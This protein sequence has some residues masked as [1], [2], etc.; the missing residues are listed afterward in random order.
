MIEGTLLVATPKLKDSTFIKTAILIIK[1]N[2]DF[3]LGVIINRTLNKLVKIKDVPNL[4][5][6]LKFGGPVPGPVVAIHHE[7]TLAEN[8][9]SNNVF[10]SCGFENINKIS[11][12]ELYQFYSGYCTWKEGQL[13]KEISEGYWIV[14]SIKNNHK[15][16]YEED[17]FIWIHLKNNHSKEF[18]EKIGLNINKHNYLLN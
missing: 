2:K 4:K 13:E 9:I 14:D 5:K 15:L 7:K 11:V 6:Y 3:K 1:T 8:T 10:Y 16:L 18:Y 17:D 12:T